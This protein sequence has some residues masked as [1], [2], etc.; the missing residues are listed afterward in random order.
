MVLVF[1][2]NGF[3]EIEALAT[4]DI[5]R[6]AGLAVTT[7]G[8]GG[9]YVTGTHGIV[10]KADCGDASAFPNEVQAVVLPGGIPGTPNL[11]ASAVVQGCVDTAVE[12]GAYV[13]A[14]CAAPS[15][16]GHKGLLRG[17]RATCY[18][19]FETELTDAIL[20]DESVVQDG[21]I[22]TAKGAGVTVDFA[23]CIVSALVSS[24][25]ARD[26]GEKMQCR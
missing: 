24:D 7:V 25:V 10:V 19:G 3:E 15:I 9:E 18:P 12:Q 13:C 14:I 26:L 16:L 23:L 21:T 8:V 4:V 22:I 1:L 17:K 20:S 6:R 2:A 5:L 11:E